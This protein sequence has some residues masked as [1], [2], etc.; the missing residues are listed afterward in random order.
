MVSSERASQK[1]Q[2]G[3]QFNGNFS[4]VASSSEELW[5]LIHGC[6][7]TVKVTTVE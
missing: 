4:S 6:F 3:T 2:N 1:E 7:R 5:V